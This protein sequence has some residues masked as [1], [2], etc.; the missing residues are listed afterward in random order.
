MVTEP[1]V[2]RRFRVGIVVLIALV[3]MMA[4][5]LMVGRR[6][7]LFRHKFPYETRFDSAAGLV[8]GNPV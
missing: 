8:A 1:Q 2:G 5:I 4:A 3:A 7:N 6:A